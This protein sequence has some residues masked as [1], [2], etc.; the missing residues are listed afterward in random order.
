MIRKLSQRT[1]LNGDL[2]LPL[3]KTKENSKVVFCGTFTAGGLKEEFRDGK[4]EIL[5]EGRGKKLVKQVEQITFS[6]EFAQQMGQKVYYIT[7]R[8]VFELTE[9][10]IALIEIAPGADLEKDILAQMDFVPIMGD[11]KLMDARLFN[12]EKMNM[13]I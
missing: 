3:G 11:V 4:L 5:Q 6:G 12:E 8:A 1:I 7:E 13:E 9:K 2:W 10:G